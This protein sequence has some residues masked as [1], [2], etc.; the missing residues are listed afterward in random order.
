[1]KKK[2]KTYS[3]DFKTNALELLKSRKNASALARELGIDV[4]LLYRWRDESKK[5]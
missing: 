1:M 2:R 4:N 5:K 3:Q